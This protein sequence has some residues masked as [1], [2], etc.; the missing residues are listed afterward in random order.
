MNSSA[1]NAGVPAR[2]TSISVD[3]LIR[4]KQAKPVRSLADLDAMAAD[5]FESDE[6]FD[7]FLHF[8]Q[9]ERH[10]DMA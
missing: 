5:I 2:R 8:T 7:D 10:R 1:G 9:A 3:E 4:A 6:E